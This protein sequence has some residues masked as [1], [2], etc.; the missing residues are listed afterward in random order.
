MRFFGLVMYFPYVGLALEYC[1][2][3]SPLLLSLDRGESEGKGKGNFEVRG[4]F[5]PDLVGVKLRN[6]LDLG[7]LPP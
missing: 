7:T 2:L 5:P 3:H 6:R 4:G 1:I